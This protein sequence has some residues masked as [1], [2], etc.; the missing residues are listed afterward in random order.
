MKLIYFG[1]LDPLH[2]KAGM[3]IMIQMGPGRQ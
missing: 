2:Q 3:W 1:S